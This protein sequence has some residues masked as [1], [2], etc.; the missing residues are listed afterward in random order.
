MTLK[1]NTLK[2]NLNVSTRAIVEAISA[3]TEEFLCVLPHECP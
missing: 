2:A 1:K 3:Q